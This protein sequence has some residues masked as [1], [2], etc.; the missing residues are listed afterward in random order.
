MSSIVPAG[1]G[2]DVMTPRPR[3]LFSLFS[4]MRGRWSWDT[5]RCV[6]C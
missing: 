4:D 6:Q 2:A 5:F 1:M 3:K